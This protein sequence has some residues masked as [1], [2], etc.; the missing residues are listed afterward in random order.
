MSLEKRVAHGLLC[1]FA[2]S[3]NLWEGLETA[4]SCE[5]FRG[6]N[7]C[8]L[9]T[10]DGNAPPFMFTLRA[11]TAEGPKLGCPITWGSGFPLESG[12]YAQQMATLERRVIMKPNQVPGIGT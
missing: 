11:G 10:K 9:S 6:V 8:I 4:N 1:S 2:D 3:S 12:N 5:L 7:P